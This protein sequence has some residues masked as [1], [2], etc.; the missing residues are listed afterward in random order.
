MFDALV[1]IGL[2]QW[3]ELAEQQAT[4]PD[5]DITWAALNPLVLVLGAVILRRHTERQLPEPF[6]SPRQ[7]HRWAEAVNGLL[8]A[9]Q[10]HN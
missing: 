10:L 8:R 4:R 2:G 5:L 7:L 9:G 6:S 3:R 1:R